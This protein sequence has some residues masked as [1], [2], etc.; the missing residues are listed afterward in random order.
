[1]TFSKAMALVKSKRPIICPNIGFQ[2]QLQQYESILAVSI[3]EIFII[4][5]RTR[6]SKAF[7]LLR[8][9]LLLL[10]RQFL[11]HLS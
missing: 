10:R 1:M 3:D 7:I 4:Y 9:P 5:F 11:E 8:A 6:S 2:N